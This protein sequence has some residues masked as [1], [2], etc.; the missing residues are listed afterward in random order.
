MCVLSTYIQIL[1]PVII[2]PVT[3]KEDQITLR[4]FMKFDFSQCFRGSEVRG[5]LEMS[6][7]Y[8][9]KYNVEI[10]FPCVAE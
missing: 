1:I 9:V 10:F 7:F 4:H 6:R 5:A 8:N 3:V 2:N